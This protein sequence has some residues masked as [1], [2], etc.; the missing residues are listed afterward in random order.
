MTIS[1]V[2]PHRGPQRSSFP[3]N[4]AVRFKAKAP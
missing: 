3:K 4:D 2:V 1:G